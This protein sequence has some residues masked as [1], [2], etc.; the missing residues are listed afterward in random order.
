MLLLHFL[1]MYEKVRDEEGMVVVNC[2]ETKARDW[3]ISQ[4]VITLL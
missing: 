2:N 3:I 4:K 1:C